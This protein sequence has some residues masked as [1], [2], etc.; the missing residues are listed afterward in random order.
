[1][2]QHNDQ[3]S[4]LSSSDS[5]I[6]CQPMAVTSSRMPFTGNDFTTL[7]SRETFDALPRTHKSHRA[8]SAAILSASESARASAKSSHHTLLQQI[9]HNQFLAGLFYEG[10][11][12]TTEYFLDYEEVRIV[13]PERPE[14]PAQSLP[15]GKVLLTNKRL[16]F[17]S[18]SLVEQNTVIA[19]GEGKSPHSYAIRSSVQDVRHFWPLE[20]KDVY[21]LRLNVDVGTSTDLIVRSSPPPC[22]G[23]LPCCCLKAWSQD[24]QPISSARN[25]QFIEL[26]ATNW[27]LGGRRRLTFDF[28]QQTPFHLLRDFT[29]Q[30]QATLQEC[31]SD[32]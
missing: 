31:R 24:G 32:N 7:E 22:F 4:L 27:I 23:C 8:A 12:P 25:S 5:A 28:H 16:L 11:K 10:E 18:C 15:P 29:V 30:L 14:E 13:N 3:K 9:N 21:F 17:L 19:V 26:V 20:L 6:N 1:M 2:A